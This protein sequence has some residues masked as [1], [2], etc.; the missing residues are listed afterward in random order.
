MLERAGLAVVVGGVAVC[1]AGPV[2]GQE[3]PEMRVLERGDEEGDEREGSAGEG[4][5]ASVSELESG[6]RERELGDGAYPYH[7][8]PREVSGEPECPDIELVDYEGSVIAYNRPI[9][10][11]REFRPRLVRFEKLVREVAREVYGRAPDRVVHY[12]GHQC[13]TVGGEGEKLSEHAFGHAIDV[14]GFDF[15]A[16]SG[17]EAEGVEPE[18]AAEAFQVR[19]GDHWGASSG[20]AG[21][22]S[23]FLHRLA[24]V[25]RRRGPFSA[26]LGPGYPGHD[27]IFHFDFGPEFFFRL[28]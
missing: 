8:R 2:W 5:E 4:E 3:A 17:E 16:V 10:I 28:E 22:H 1:V 27:E 7:D 21:R 6:A 14:V 18:R 24:E 25:L 23:E 9:E 26:M 15:E 19:V 20:F 13:K 11:N 12:G